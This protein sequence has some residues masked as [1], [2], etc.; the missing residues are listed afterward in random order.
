MYTYAYICIIIVWY[1][2]KSIVPYSTKDYIIT[3]Y[4]YFSNAYPR[5]KDRTGQDSNSTHD[6]VTLQHN[7]K[8]FKILANHVTLLQPC[9]SCLEA[10]LST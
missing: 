3:A 1:T 6:A 5:D 9:V 10:L 4:I 8:P 7:K 2:G